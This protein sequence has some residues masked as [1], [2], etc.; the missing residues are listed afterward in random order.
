MYHD[1]LSSGVEAI[2]T[3]IDRE[4]E[5]WFSKQSQAPEMSFFLYYKSPKDNEAVGDLSISESCPSE[6]W[7]SAGG[8]RISP[9]LKKIKYVH[10]CTS[11]Q[12]RCH[13]SSRLSKEP[14]L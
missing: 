10:T 14:S 8:A 1:E 13:Y 7:K 4:V 5:S 2:S 6:N 9:G 11:N 12:C 3:A